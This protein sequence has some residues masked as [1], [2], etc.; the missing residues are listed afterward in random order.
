MLKDQ[1]D[2]LAVFNSH[3]VRYL[4]VGAHAVGVH[5]EPRG[6]KDLDVFIEAS[7]I[8][9]EAVFAA[10]AE[11]GAPLAGMTPD[12]FNDE[13]GSVFQLGTP[14]SRVDILQKIEGVDFDEAWANRIETSIAAGIPTQVISLEDLI[15]NKLAVGRPQDLIDVEKI[16]EAARLK[17][18][19]KP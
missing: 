6:T 10:L 4:I 7:P 15:R 13:P 3:G 14:P 11:F 16:R 18:I 5:A 17:E 19:R 12:D 1:K 2:L 9:S 8:N